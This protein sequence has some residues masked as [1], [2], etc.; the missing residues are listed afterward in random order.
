VKCLD[1]DLRLGPRKV[2]TVRGA[3]GVAEKPC[4]TAP[5]VACILLNWNGWQDTV[6]CLAALAKVT[7]GNFSIVVVDNGSRNDSVIRIREACPGI[8]L[9]ETGKNLGFAGGNNVGI[10][11]AIDHGAE[12]I[13]LLNNDTEPRPT[14]LTELVEKALSNPKLGAIGSTLMYAHDP[15][16]VQAW[17]G[18][19]I[20]VWIGRSF[21]TLVPQKDDWFD[22]ITAA[23]LLIPRQALE[24]VGLLDE[25]FFLYWEDGDLG[26]RLR[27][28]G[29]KLGVAADSIV[30]HKEHASTGRNRRVIDRY[31]ITSG[32]RFLNKHSPAPWLSIPLFLS[33]RMWKRLLTGQFRGIGDLF[34]GIGDYLFPRPRD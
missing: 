7:Y 4:V 6:A 32:I 8:T 31:V 25:G 2:N 3:D 15:G 11:Y 1:P 20:N 14:A 27:E 18:G 5:T 13:W 34:G 28:G 29:W 23:S 26:F 24:D 12:Y 22:Y 30:L 19:R 21:H 16:S 33:L 9:L 17:G 10:R